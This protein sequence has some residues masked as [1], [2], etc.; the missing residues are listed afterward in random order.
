MHYILGTRLGGG[1]TK[2][3]KTQFPKGLTI[4]LR[5]VDK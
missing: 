2:K 1:D 5:E 3:K 4:S